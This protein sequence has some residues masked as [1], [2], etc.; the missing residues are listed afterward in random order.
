M[1]ERV[2][3]VEPTPVAWDESTKN[4]YNSIGHMFSTC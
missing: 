1:N 4:E 2:V 3:S